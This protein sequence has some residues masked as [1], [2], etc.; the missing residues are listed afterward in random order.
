MCCLVKNKIRI[1]PSFR[2]KSEDVIPSSLL[3]ELFE[4][5]ETNVIFE[6]D[7][8][9]I[10][11]ATE[12]GKGDQLVNVRYLICWEAFGNGEV[13]LEYCLSTEM[14]VDTLTTPSGLPK[15]RAITVR[16]PMAFSFPKTA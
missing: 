16:M 1:D 5:V 2:M 7:Q 3:W 9:C 13:R 14:M 12:K 4:G 6:G 10:S 8:P 15:F 11:W